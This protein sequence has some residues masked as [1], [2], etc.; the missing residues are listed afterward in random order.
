MALGH[1]PV[2]MD[3]QP[4]P[5][6]GYNKQKKGLWSGIKQIFNGSTGKPRTRES[7]RNARSRP[8]SNDLQS[9][10]YSCL[11][12]GKRKEEEEAE[13]E[14]HMRDSV[15]RLSRNLSLSH[16]SVFQMEPHISQVGNCCVFQLLFVV[17]DVDYL[18][19]HTTL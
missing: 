14:Y 18:L 6:I 7:G 15:A 11:G 16:E 13:L 8:F 2:D 10:S 19:L 5:Q 4:L 1:I 3:G 17:S 9:L 12:N